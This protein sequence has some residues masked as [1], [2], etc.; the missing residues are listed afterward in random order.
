[1]EEIALETGFD[2]PKYLYRLFKAQ[3]GLSPNAYRRL[4]LTEHDDS[5]IT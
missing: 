4:Y 5:I 2:S 3:E 1:M